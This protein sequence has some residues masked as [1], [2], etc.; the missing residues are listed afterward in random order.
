[1]IRS[2]ASKL[3]ASIVGLVGTPATIEAAFAAAGITK[4]LA[5]RNKQKM[6]CWVWAAEEHVW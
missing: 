3:I 2:D 6:E 4:S 5:L 1:V